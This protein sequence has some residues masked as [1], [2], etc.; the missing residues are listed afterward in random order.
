MTNLLLD[1]PL[2]ER[3]REFASTIGQSSAA[4]LEIINDRLDFSKIEAGQMRLELE[5][6]ALRPL[7]A[8]VLQPGPTPL[9]PTCA[10][11]APTLGFNPQ[12][13]TQLCAELGAEGVQAIIV[14]F[15]SDLPLRV[16]EMEALAA[17]GQLPDLARCAHA[18]QGISRTLGLAGFGAQLL[19][20]EEV[21]KVEAHAPVALQMAAL[22][23]AVAPNITALRAWLAAQ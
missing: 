18:L 22:T 9:P 12:T 3:Q 16:G 7:V 21:A 23:A 1:T 15:L 4:L 8:D 10:N 19:A 2:D 13:P 17:A 6:C 11:P 5:A 20:V 14:D